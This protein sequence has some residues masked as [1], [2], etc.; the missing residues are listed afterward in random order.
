[1]KIF[2]NYLKKMLTFKTTRVILNTTKKDSIQKIKKVLKYKD[3]KKVLK[4]IQKVQ[5]K[6]IQKE[7]VQRYEKK[8]KSI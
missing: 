3:T 6:I 5:N 1:M 7:K 8:K 4:I 2:Q